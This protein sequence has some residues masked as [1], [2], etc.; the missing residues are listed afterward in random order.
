MSNY[1]PRNNEHMN[2]VNLD[3]EDAHRAG[4]QYN[5]NHGGYP[6]GGNANQPL[7]G[8]YEGDEDKYLQV[9]HSDDDE[10]IGGHSEDERN[11][12]IAKVYGIVSVQLI[13]T[14]IIA[15]FAIA[16]S[17]FGHFL[18]TNM[19]FM[20][21][22]M[23]GVIITELMIVCSTSCARKVPNNYILLFTFTFFESMLVASI[24]AAVND[25]FIV[26]V[27]AVM[28]SAVVAVLTIYAFTTKKD[29]TT[30]GSI[31]WVFLAALLMA[32]LFMIIFQSRI[33]HI[34]YCAAAVILFGFILI[35]DTQMI[36][37]KGQYG[38]SGDDYIIGAMMIYVDIITIFV[39]LLSLL[40]EMRGD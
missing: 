23:V 7:Y 14:S 26:F 19:W 2:Y 24:C 21:L 1:Q 15:L 37:G 29:F 27:A 28:T 30:F 36:Q 5:Q 38:L 3:N 8:K 9:E 40:A 39:Q 12:F 25:P 18:V 4:N 22:C 13:V 34:I 10:Y 35:V 33:L 31:L 32:G 17:S 6:M 11:D 20:I 16:S